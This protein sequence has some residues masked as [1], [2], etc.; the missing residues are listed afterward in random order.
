MP[1]LIDIGAYGTEHDRLADPR[2]DE[3][4]DLSDRKWCCLLWYIVAVDAEK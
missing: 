4:R 3:N 1:H 2:E